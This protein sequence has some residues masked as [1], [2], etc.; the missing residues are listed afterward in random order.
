[1]TKP[2]IDTS[3]IIARVKLMLTKPTECWPTIAAE[4]RTSKELVTSLV[5]PLSAMGALSAFLAVQAYVP[6][7]FRPSILW[8]VINVGWTVA[9]TVILLYVFSFLTT[10]LAPLFKGSPDPAKA[11]SWLTHASLVPLAAGIFALIPWVSPIIALAANIFALVLMW[12]GIPSMLSIPENQRLF[13]IIALL[14]CMLVASGIVVLG[15]GAFFVA[16]P[17]VAPLAP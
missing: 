17:M 8:G 15:I 4:T 11:F 7:I 14:V 1:M 3:F 6:S 10:K 12:K 9:A 2:A 5:L 13:F 16:T